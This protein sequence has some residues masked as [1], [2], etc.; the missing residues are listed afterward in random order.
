MEMKYSI[1]QRFGF[2]AFNVVLAI[3]MILVNKAIFTRLHFNFPIAL[4]T[5]HYAFTWLGLELLR[6]I[7]VYRQ[8]PANEMPLTQ[9]DIA[10][11]ILLAIVGVPLNNLSLRLEWRG[12]VSSF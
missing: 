6:R 2:L 8:I 3:L 1:A 7:G 5:V 10:S 4:T 12:H 11:C 9:F